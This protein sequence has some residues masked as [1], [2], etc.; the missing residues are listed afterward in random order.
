MNIF[1]GEVEA[2]IGGKKRLIKFG[3]NQLAIYTAKHKINPDEVEFG[4]D[5]FRDLLWSGLVAGAKKR[6]ESVDFDEWT[7]GD[8]MD[9]MSMQQLESIMDAFNKSMPT[10]D[11]QAEAKKKEPAQ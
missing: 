4:M 7:V 10:P 9:D 5:Q 2:E 6:G 8:W 1:R 11:A 3:T